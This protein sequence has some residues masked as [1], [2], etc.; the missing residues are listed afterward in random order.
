MSV[1]LPY[2]PITPQVLA[3]ANQFI[4]FTLV[5]LPVGV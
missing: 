5:L 2:S 4:H 1:Y 3:A